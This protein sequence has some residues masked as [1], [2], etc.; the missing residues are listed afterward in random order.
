MNFE[1]LG[2]HEIKFR[3]IVPNIAK[4]GAAIAAAHDRN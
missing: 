3:E 2:K 4:G 1:D